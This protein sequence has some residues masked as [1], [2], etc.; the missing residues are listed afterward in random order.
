MIKYPRAIQGAI[1]AALFKGKVVVIYGARQ[2]GKTTLLRKVYFYDLGIRNALINNFNAL[3]L[4]PDT[5]AL[6][7]NFFIAE[8][9]KYN[10]NC[11]RRVNVYFWRTYD[12]TE[13]DY[14]EEADGQLTAFACKW[15]GAR[16]RPPALF[17]AAY[18]QS[19]MHL[20]N[21]ANYLDFL[22]A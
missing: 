4:R 18:P 12:G 15:T 9:L 17:A 6:W 21:R 5:G 16:W 8:R 3:D 10:H 1:E 2:V 11:R 7:E 19:A 20:V 22:T 14:L 13:L